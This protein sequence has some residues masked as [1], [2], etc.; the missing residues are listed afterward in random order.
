MTLVI[1]GA[2]L[3]VAVLVVAQPTTAQP[4]RSQEALPKVV[5]AGSGG[6]R[7]PLSLAQKQ[8]IEQ[9]YV[10]PDQE[11]YER[12]KAKA[13]QK[14]EQR[15]GEVQ[16]SAPGD[17]APVASRSW[18]GV[19]DT[20]SSPSDS[21][22][23]I[24]PTRYIELVNRKFAI[25]NRT[26]NTP[27]SSG[28][29]QNLV[30]T[31]PNINVFDPQ[32]IW[33]PSTN[34]FYYVTDTVFSKTD[35]RLSWGFSKT[36]T[37]NSSADFCKYEQKFGSSFPDFPKL[38]DLGGTSGLLLIGTDVYDTTGKFV[39]ADL[40]SVTKPTTA[41]SITKCP[42]A[43]TF[44]WDRQANLADIFAPV[45]ANQTDISSTGYV[46]A[47]SRSV[48]ASSLRIYKVIRDSTGG[49]T[50]TDTDNQAVA[51]YSVPADAPQPGTTK[52]IETSDCRLTQAVS[53][54]DPRYGKTALWTQ[55]TAFGGGGAQVRWYEIS[56]STATPTML[57]NGVTSTAHPFAYNGAISPDRKVLSGATSKFGSNMVLTFNTSS[58]SLRPEIRMVS[59]I[60]AG[61]QSPSVLIKGSPASLNEFTCDKGV[62][63]WGDYAAA[64]PD[65]ATP[66]SATT[67]NVWLTSNY[68]R[69]T[70]STNS[71]G[72]G[73]WNWAARP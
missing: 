30:G 26:S 57:Q 25:Y 69:A 36:S 40:N 21:T 37:P 28:S 53:A 22:G 1:V 60:G 2:L 61:A 16:P 68:V 8:A 39:G 29:L 66:S 55:L 73:T 50:I 20:N 19:F 27:V 3:A 14:A 65:P 54:F 56:P 17:K 10:V 35:N 45:P 51:S 64:T 58:S 11:A 32:V 34:R 9:G 7:G 44:K 4:S 48:P 52:K 38:G 47:R 59:K 41:G 49:F 63:R 46:V 5:K 71:A 42:S 6:E 31:P 70:G 33:D 24:G 67:G 43:S 15:S 23:A 13:A 18:E 72:W 12:A 62:C